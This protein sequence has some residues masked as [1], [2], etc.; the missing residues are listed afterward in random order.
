MQLPALLAACLPLRLYSRARARDETRTQYE[1]G[2]RPRSALERLDRQTAACGTRELVRLPPCV[3][4]GTT[5]RPESARELVRKCALLV[6]TGQ[7]QG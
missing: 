2:E 4:Q 7:A 6:T 1:I 5:W 3:S